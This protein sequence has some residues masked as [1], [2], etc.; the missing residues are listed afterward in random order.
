MP[1]QPITINRYSCT[2]CA[3]E[4]QGRLTGK[5]NRCPHCG[6]PYWD[7]PYTRGKPKDGPLTP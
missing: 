1:T 7:R 4:W 6:S 3:Y 2:R 5:P